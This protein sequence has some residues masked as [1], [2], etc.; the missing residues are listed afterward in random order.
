MP[1]KTS[2][3]TLTLL[4]TLFSIVA[5]TTG[6]FSNEGTNA[7]DY[8]TIRGETIEIYGR[9]VYKHMSSQVAIQGIAQDYITLFIAVPLLLISLYLCRKGSIRGKFLL[10]GTLL[11]LL[12][13]YLFYTAMAMYNPLFLIY[14]ALLALSLNALI[15]SLISF[16]TEK[17]KEVIHS[18]RITTFAGWFLIVNSSMIALLWLNTIVTPLL[19]GTIYPQGIDHY[20]TMIVQGFDLG[21]FLPLGFMSGLLAIKKKI[22][23]VLFSTTYVIFL[24]ILMA[25]LTSK[26]VFMAKAGANVIPVVFIM[27]TICIISIVVATLLMKNLEASIHE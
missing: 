14:V 23:G 24:S 13:T 22:L 5:T 25:A 27:P 1:H 20:T 16:D 19:S 21:I 11:Y 2:I 3:T 17:L 6:I 4:I 7:Y 18:Q 15:L 8:K 10:T 26:I 12:L 9:G